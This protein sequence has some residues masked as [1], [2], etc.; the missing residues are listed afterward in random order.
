ME[1]VGYQRHTHIKVSCI[2]NINTF[3][4]NNPNMFIR[5]QIR[6]QMGI[7]GCMM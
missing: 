7:G 3:T 1:V 2:K 6:L 4:F 5:L